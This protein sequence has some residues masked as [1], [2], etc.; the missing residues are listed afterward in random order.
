MS[1]EDLKGFRFRES[2][3]A[4][5]ETEV[6]LRFDR[7]GGSVSGFSGDVSMEG[8]FVR[9]EE[10]KPVGTLV[11]FEFRVDDESEMI[12]GLGDIVWIR[13]RQLAPN[14]PPGMGIQFRY[15]D[16]RS[17]ELIFRI[18]DRYL[19]ETKSGVEKPK[20]EPGSPLA[21]PE[22]PPPAAPRPPAVPQVPMAT[23][24]PAAAAPPALPSEASGPPVPELSLPAPDAPAESP[25]TP[26]P[27]LELPPPVIEPP[28]A[29]DSKEGRALEPAPL[30]P[31]AELPASPVA[32]PPTPEP[33][34]PSSEVPPAAP[35]RE[36]SP[37]R[38]AVEEAPS[39]SMLESTQPL[40]PDRTPSALRPLT[41]QGVSSQMA[42]PPAQAEGEAPAEDEAEL[43]SEPEGLFELE[44]PGDELADPGDVLSLGDSADELFALDPV[45]AT[46][47]LENDATTVLPPPMESVSS[48]EGDEGD[49]GAAAVADEEA[50]EA[51][52]VAPAP[53]SDDLFVAQRLTPAEIGGVVDRGE[54]SAP[55]AAEPSFYEPVD[56]EAA[57]VPYY[58]GAANARAGGGKRWLLVAALAV[59]LAGA[60]FFFRQELLSFLPGSAG[61]TPAGGEA[62]GGEVGGTPTATSSVAGPVPENGSSPGSESVAG[63]DTSAID[64]S[65]PATTTPTSTRPVPTATPG[66]RPSRI[67]ELAAVSV[68]GGTDIRITTDGALSQGSFSSSLLQQPPRY[69]L[70]I[71]GV[72]S[73]YVGRPVTAPELKGM[74]SGLHEPPTG[75]E[76]HLVFDLASDQVTATSEI[77]GGVLE[78]HLRTNG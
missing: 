23:P 69:L 52:P 10:P 6:R 64:T 54:P 4:P 75:P 71:Q 62:V 26:V 19:K 40:A 22:S 8:M 48:F 37:A 38:P 16:P 13:T 20:P 17:R 77:V 2:T 12:Q 14:K 76:I 42:P 66:T 65:T 29:P 78:V 33:P 53:K 72:D 18:V 43:P 56:E 63:T 24:P 55:S 57:P 70:R 61:E 3:R 31:P 47:A 41:E 21:A 73:P 27:S 7:F 32:T 39:A 28:P 11:Q 5:F 51:S 35:A 74:R 46:D 9:S 25:P 59:V 30:P 36:L 58:G 45:P 49:L 60:G 67:V 50:E 44:P 34:A 68:G 1:Q 15:V